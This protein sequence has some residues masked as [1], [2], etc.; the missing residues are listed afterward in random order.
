MWSRFTLNVRVTARRIIRRPMINFSLF[1]VSSALVL[2]TVFYACER[3][4]GAPY[5]TYLGTLKG[6]TILVMSGFD[7]ASPQS[8]GAWI[9]SYFLLG[10]GIVYVGLLSGVIAAALIESRLGRGITMGKLNFV[11]HVLICGWTDRGTHILDQL[12]SSDLK[13][14]R[15]VVIID[16][17]IDKSPSEHPL[18]RVIKGDPTDTAI[19]MQANAIKA[20]SAI[21]LANRDARDP[22]MS[23]ARSLLITL[24]VETLQPEIYSCVEVLNPD[25]VIHF[26][27]A[28][29]DEAISVTEIS[30]NLLSHAALNP[31][32]SRLILDMLSFGEGEELYQTD[33]PRSFVG[34]SFA[35]LSA[36]LA[37]EQDM[38]LVGISSDRGIVNSHRASWRFKEGDRIFFLAESE[39]DNLETLL[40][41]Q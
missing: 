23:D 35:D 15:P 6:I 9:C 8:I 17:N 40:S 27:R 1:S 41:D 11:G 31:G 26:K 2:S 18:L 12:F 22:N 7:V 10:L 32:T 24:A 28:N 20:S 13:E 36:V 29:V 16:P 21:V 4:Y 25:N 38:V 39:P 30:N 19:L 33:V 34:K 3:E 14:C 37:H 5:D